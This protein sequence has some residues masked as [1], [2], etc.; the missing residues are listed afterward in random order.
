MVFTKMWQRCI[1]R[2]NQLKSR[3]KVPK[4]VFKKLF[5]PFTKYMCHTFLRHTVCVLLILKH[6]LSNLQQRFSRRRDY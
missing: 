1:L 2:Q 3:P 4:F 5:I 6:A